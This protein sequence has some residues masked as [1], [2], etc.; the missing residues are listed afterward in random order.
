MLFQYYH[1]DN[2]EFVICL[3]DPFCSAV[4]EKI[5]ATSQKSYQVFIMPQC[6]TVNPEIFAIS[7]F[8]RKALNNIFATLKICD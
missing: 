4:T 1:Y 3:F 2:C 7:L 5:K 8:T 6:Y